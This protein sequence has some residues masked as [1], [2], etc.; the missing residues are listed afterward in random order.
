MRFKVEVFLALLFGGLALI[1]F[2]QPILGY[3]FLVLSGIILFD[4]IATR[5]GYGI[6][7]ASPIKFQHRLGVKPLNT[8]KLNTSRSRLIHDGVLWEDGGTNVWGNMDV[9]GPLCP[10]DYTPLAMK[11]RDRINTDIS[12]RAIIST[13]GDDYKL[14]CLECNT[15]YSLGTRPKRIV[16]SRSEVGNRFEGKRRRSQ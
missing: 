16:D 13:S 7:F 8:A 4:I 14:V 15:K 2:I 12:Y 9:I 1:G 10:K 3:V 11:E 6:T 5:K